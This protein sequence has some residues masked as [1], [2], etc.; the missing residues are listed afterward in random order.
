MSGYTTQLETHLHHNHSKFV[1]K[2]WE[3][4]SQEGADIASHQ[5]C[6]HILG[7]S[8]SGLQKLLNRSCLFH[9]RPVRF[10]SAKWAVLQAANLAARAELMRLVWVAIPPSGWA[11][12]HSTGIDQTAKTSTAKCFFFYFYSICSSSGSVYNVSHYWSVYRG[13][14][15]ARPIWSDL[16]GFPQTMSRYFWNSMDQLSMSS[17][18]K[19]RVFF[20]QSGQT[21]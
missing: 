12:T 1:E 14:F 8:C 6:L 20:R 17:L 15:R 11:N 16:I 4:P 18:N 21:N 2:I 5:S 10:G 7:T 3:L 19:Q 9:E 13:G